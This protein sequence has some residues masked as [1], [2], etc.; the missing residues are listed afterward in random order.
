MIHFSLAKFRAVEHRRYLV[1]STNTGISGFIDPLGHSYNETSLGKFETQIG[2]IHYMKMN[3]LYE[4]IG[5][6]PF[7]IISILIFI[8]GFIEFSP[9]KKI[10]Y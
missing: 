6:I 4:I 9:K 5:D 8:I 1:R 3:T 10:P 2:D 7:W